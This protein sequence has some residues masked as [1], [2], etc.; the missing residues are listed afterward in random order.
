MFLDIF[1]SKKKETKPAVDKPQQKPAVVKPS[2]KKKNT[3]IICFDMMINPSWYE[4]CKCTPLVVEQKNGQNTFN[5]GS[6]IQT[7]TPFPNPGAYAMWNLYKEAPEWREIAGA[8]TAKTIIEYLDKTTG[9]PVLIVYPTGHVKSL[10]ANEDEN[11]VAATRLNHATRQDLERQW[12]RTQELVKFWNQHQ[13][14][15]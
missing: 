14:I 5:P 15:M 3:Y 13:K 6:A 1:N 8:K 4:Y 2:K 9:E 11:T 10:V 12:K 7:A